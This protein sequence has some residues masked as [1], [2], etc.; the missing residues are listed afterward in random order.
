MKYKE[1]IGNLVIYEVLI[2]CV[3]LEMFT[4]TLNSIT[5]YGISNKINFILLVFIQFARTI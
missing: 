4:V 3:V 1:E 2:A 5:S